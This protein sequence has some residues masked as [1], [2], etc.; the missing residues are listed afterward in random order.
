MQF[1]RG[2]LSPYFVTDADRME[3]SLDEPVVLITKKIGMDLLPILEQVAKMG[4]PL[5]IIA[6]RRRS[7]YNPGC[8]HKLRGTLNVAAVKAPAGDRRKAMLEDIAILTGGKVISETSASNK[9]SRSKISAGKKITID[10]KT[11]PS[12]KAAVLA[13][14]SWPLWQM[15][16]DRNPSDYT[17]KNCRNVWPNWSAAL[18]SRSNCITRPR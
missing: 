1:D 15:Q 3:A 16:P 5:L 14:R 4:K 11:P 13:M 17:V 7:P 6:R 10:W 2:Y 12:S 8:K 9:R 18:R